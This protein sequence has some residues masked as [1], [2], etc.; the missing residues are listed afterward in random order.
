MNG[1]FEN[2]FK[3]TERAEAP[4]NWRELKE[5]APKQAAVRIEEIEGFSEMNAQEQMDALDTLI[6]E[7]SKNN[8]HRY[9]ARE[10]SI[11]REQIR[12]NDRHEKRMIE[13]GIVV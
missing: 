13:L 7:L 12:E 6:E 10:I 4:S 8:E 1:N 9:V 11:R 3:N 2:G 5:E